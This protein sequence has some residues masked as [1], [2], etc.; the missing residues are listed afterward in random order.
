VIK[1]RK[2]KE[3]SPKNYICVLLSIVYRTM[4]QRVRENR[5]HRQ[6]SRV[7]DM[8]REVEGTGDLNGT[9]GVR[10]TI[11]SVVVQ[12]REHILK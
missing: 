10:S 1:G 5:R 3:Y 9:H 7:R 8:C 11:S 6:Q 12:K 2:N 4:Y